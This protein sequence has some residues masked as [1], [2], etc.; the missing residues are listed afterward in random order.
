MHFPTQQDS[1]HLYFDIKHSCPFSSH[2]QLAQ[3]REFPLREHHL[4]P[5]YANT[6]TQ[7]TALATYFY[8]LDTCRAIHHGTA[9]HL[10]RILSTTRLGSQHHYNR[11]PTQ[12]PY[13]RRNCCRTRRRR[14]PLPR[15][16]RPF[17][18]LLPR[19]Q[20]IQPLLRKPETTSLSRTENLRRS[21]FIEFLLQFTYT[22]Q[23]S[24]RR[25]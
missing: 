18:L 2:L 24:P 3:K 22:T 15:R 8:S 19:K 17:P 11:Q 16:H 12:R 25:G 10:T 6:L 13:L 23:S 7:S 1:S 5:R 4:G 20:S 14:S 21:T 9:K